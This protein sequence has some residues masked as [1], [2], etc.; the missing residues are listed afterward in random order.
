[1]M[2]DVA[3][4]HLTDVRDGLQREIDRLENMVADIK[5]KLEETEKAAAWR[6]DEI[7][8][9]NAA[10]GSVDHNKVPEP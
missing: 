8:Q 7:A 4:K 1:M 2:N 3:K 5:A 10:L 6:R 9:I